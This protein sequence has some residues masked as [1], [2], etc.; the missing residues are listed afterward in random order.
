MSEVGGVADIVGGATL[1]RAV[2]SRAGE[3]AGEVARDGHTHETHCLNCGAALTGAFCS[4]CGQ[5]AHVHRTLAAFFHDLAHGVFHFE[6]T[7][8]RT[9]P[10]LAFHPGQLTREYIDGRR[11]TYV[12]PIA[13]FLFTVF[14]MFAALGSG[15]GAPRIVPTM[16]SKL[17]T[18]ANEQRFLVNRLKQERATA[19]AAGKTVAALDAKIASETSDLNVLEGL[20]TRKTGS[21]KA[22]FDSLPG[23]V[24]NAFAKARANPDLALYKVRNSAYKY[25]WALI[26]ISVPFVWLLFPFSRRFRMYDHTVFVTYSLSFMM[27]LV[28]GG[29]LLAMG[30]I[31]GFAGV[32]ALIPPVHLYSQ[33]KGAYGLSRVGALWRT[34]V[35]VLFTF[36]AVTM[37]ALIMIALGVLD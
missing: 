2:E 24:G 5:H 30:G 22:D 11:A 9:L 27:V 26:P 21:P 4:A 35:L 7:T 31:G 12:S 8:W 29:S 18:V 6:G 19:F 17:D 34:A 10:L 28:I 1:A 37:F 32:L 33:L 14:L 16:S 3:G 23:W 20:P 25:S 13:L 15:T 36:V